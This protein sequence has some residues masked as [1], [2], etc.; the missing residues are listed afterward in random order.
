MAKKILIVGNF[1]FHNTG[2]EAILSALILHLRELRSGLEICVVSGDAKHTQDAFHVAAVS[3]QDI[4]A[5]IARAEECDLIILGG[6]GIFNDYWGVQ[7][8]TILTR[9]HAGI[10]FYSEVAVLARLLDKPLSIFGV[11]VG[12]L[13]SA[14]GREWTRLA[15]SLANRASV[16]DAGTKR[17]L[18]QIG[19]ETGEIAVT[20][21]PAFCLGRDEQGAQALISRLLPN[22]GLPLVAISLRNWNVN[23]DQ[24]K[25]QREVAQGLDRFYE[26]RPCNSLFLPFHNLPAYPLTDDL[27]A[28]K[29]VIALL[30]HKENA[31]IL[32]GQPAPGTVAGVIAHCGLVIGMRLHAVIFAA[33]AGVPIVALSYDPKVK[34]MMARLGLTDFSLNLEDV[35]AEKLLAAAQ[36]AVTEREQIHALLA[37]KYWT[38]K[39]SAEKNFAFVDELLNGKRKTAAKEDQAAGYIKWLA[40]KQSRLLFEQENTASGLARTLSEKEALAATLQADLDAKTATIRQLTETIRMQ[41]ERLKAERARLLALEMAGMQKD[42]TIDA[43]SRLVAGKEQIIQ[44]YIAHLDA[45]S[46]SRGWKFLQFMWTVR[47]RLIPKGS[48]RERWLKSF[49]QNFKRTFRKRKI[50]P[51]RLFRDGYIEQ[52]H[53]TVT[54]Y[55]DDPDIFPG[56]APRSRL[57]T[58][59]PD[60]LKVSLIVTVK[61]EKHNVEQW[62]EEIRAQRRTPDEIVIADGGSTDGTFELLKARADHYPIPLKL[63]EAA[64]ANRSAARN[65]AIRQ[66]RHA[67]IAVTDFGCRIP[68]EWLERLIRPF[69]IDADTRVSAGFYRVAPG[70]GNP[71]TRQQLWAN[72]NNVYPQS[73]LPSSRSV[74]FTRQAVEAVGGHPEWLVTAGDDTYLDLEL[75]RLG[76]RWAF[77]PGAVVEWQAPDSC[78]AFLRKNYQW[79]GGDGESGVHARY[80][81]RYVVR[82]AGWA[83]ISL[84]AV[85][86]II[87]FCVLPVRPAW[88]WSL[89]V[90]AAFLAGLWLAARKAGT[91][92]PVLIPKMSG[93]IAQVLGFIG[94][95][96]RR[97]EVAQRRYALLKG[98]IFILAGVPMEDTGGGSR[99]AQIGDELLRQGYL[100]I[101][102][103]KF[104][105]DESRELEIKYAHPNLFTFPLSEFDWDQ[106][107]AE[108]RDALA[109]K[110]LGAMVEFPLADFLPL[111]EKVSSCGGKILY[112]LIDD[113]RSS[114]GGSWYSTET[115]ARIVRASDALSATAAPLR[116]RLEKLSRRPVAL[117]PNAVNLHLFDPTAKYRRPADLPDSR[118]II[119]YIGALWGDWFDWDLLGQ[120]ARQYRRVAV[121]VIGDY[122]GQCKNPPPNLKF[123]GLKPQRDLP[124]YLAS[125]R[126]AIIPWKRSPITLATNP[127]KLYEYLAMRCPVVAPDWLPLAGMPGV[128]RARD[129]KEFVALIG[130][131]GRSKLDENAI[132]EFM[133]KNDW[134]TRAGQMLELLGF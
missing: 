13:A 80:Y 72:L 96:R 109:G 66:A 117:V 52:D 30:K 78:A 91:A 12:P 67:L 116:E 10:A 79:A 92:L 108:N 115:E 7:P 102:I 97:K 11:G 63:I 82:I 99:G 74:A 15:F 90:G 124:A 17:L 48:R 3:W 36:K 64:G 122:R 53:S 6:G 55:T 120:V 35:N 69:L 31:A 128:L 33:S 41:K 50:L 4:P 43:Q 5:V 101:Y 9:A 129:Q 49:W 75:K 89:L 131:A 87:F 44:D 127:L 84:A 100:V 119:L 86:A 94:G 40:L 103:N 38:L 46:R 27:N 39:R 59:R 70:R 130:R 2:D 114:L 57:S 47:L 73:F 28:V 113:W 34:Q 95:A 19:C 134:Q 88:L 22:N 61:N 125:S 18:Q 45:I 112:D 68:P 126:V 21:D 24:D 20:A 32:R 132:R 62:L 56:Y 26:A 118:R 121:C 1:G 98:A 60:D 54:L 111:I 93:E 77:V 65:I 76:G 25:W 42:H 83:A 133:A 110:K 8:E 23:C 58:A 105:R 51:P 85:G 16:R 81:W 37:G 29:A 104:P 106:F 71:D 107:Y 123:L 14:A